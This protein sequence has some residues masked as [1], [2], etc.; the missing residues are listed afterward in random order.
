MKL[1]SSPDQKS[2]EALIKNL[3][4]L[5]TYSLSNLWPWGEIYTHTDTHAHTHTH[6]DTHAHTHI[7]THT[8]T[9]TYLF[10]VEPLAVG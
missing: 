1:V 5:A 7:R 2:I 10:T 4:I 3:L 9:H 6:T 8:H